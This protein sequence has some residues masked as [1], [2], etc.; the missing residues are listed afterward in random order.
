MVR[1]EAGGR[2]QAVDEDEA[3]E[4]EDE[5]EEGWL[6]STWEGK[7]QERSL[8]AQEREVEPEETET[9]D[10]NDDDGDDFGDDFDEFAEGEEHNDFGDF[11]E[12]QKA[13]AEPPPIPTTPSILAGLVSSSHPIPTTCSR[14]ASHSARTQ[15]VRNVS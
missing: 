5:D 13:A 14:S 8:P 2:E 1:D 4:G 7:V 12:P 10:D 15:T 11:D 9:D 3:E 6:R